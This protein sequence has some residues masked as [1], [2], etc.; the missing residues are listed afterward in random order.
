MAG[1]MATRFQTSGTTGEP[2]TW[3]RDAAQLRAEATI[4]AELCSAGQADGIV[5][6]APPTHLYGHLMGRALPE[7]TRLPCRVLPVTAPIASGFAGFRRP[8]VAALPAAAVALAR[9]LPTLRG[10]ERMT[11][12]HGSAVLTQATVDLLTELE[13][14]AAL[15]E[16]FGST[17]T[18]LVGWRSRPTGDW[19]PAP[20]VTLAEVPDGRLR[21]TGPR[22][23][24]REGERARPS[25][26]L[27]DLV[28]VNPDQT[29]RWHGRAGHLLK[30]NG[31]RVHLD[32]VEAVLRTAVPGVTLWCRPERDPVRGEWFCVLVTSA[33]QVEAVR[34]ACA[35]LPPVARPRTVRV[36]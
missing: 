13:G 8:L 2:V 28:T 25:T 3:L 10:L 35:A 11:L 34:S 4:L 19:S 9:G 24:R 17:E 30:V 20:D 6:Y 29:F 23:A 36:A 16:L 14:R 15:V 26:V 1:L 27:D 22:I 32:Q 31:R 33:D 21:V 12:V 18:G 7:L 5:C